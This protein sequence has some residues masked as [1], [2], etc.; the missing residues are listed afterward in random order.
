MFRVPFI[1]ASVNGN[2][3][4]AAFYSALV[5]A[6]IHDA[7]GQEADTVE[8]TFDD[9]NNSV[10]MP[11]KGAVIVVRFGF[12]GFGGQKMG[13]FIVESSSIE[14]GE[15]GEFLKVSGRSADMRSDVKEPVS[16]HFDDM[17][18]GEV[19]RRLATRHG[20]SA[21]VDPSIASIRLPYTA[22]YEQGATDFLTRIADR[23]GALF[24][25]KDGKFLMLP[26][27]TLPPVTIDK[28]ECE[29]WSFHVE[30]RPLFGKAEAGWF[31]RA[32]G[33][34]QFES[35]ETGLQGATRRLRRVLPSQAEAKAAAKSEGERLGRATGSGS[36]TLAGRP[37][38]MADAPIT[39]TGFRAEANGL[40]RCASVDHTYDDTYKTSIEL[41]APE[42]GKT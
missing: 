12:R 23:F 16:E 5:S 20:Y 31:D 19:V 32:S 33:Q 36:I 13:R 37:D 6:R 3:V 8:L 34:V 39:T 17:T 27:G 9:S 24:A 30:P 25:I 21:K 40:W 22:R 10:T 1:E 28:P 42:E 4:A 41:E 15:S 29:G 14:G 11:A 7:P 2:P 35:H 38:I 18:V 26:H